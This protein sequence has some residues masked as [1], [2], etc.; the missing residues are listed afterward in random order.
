MITFILIALAAMTNA[1]MDTIAFHF[2]RS[3]FKHSTW[4]W[5]VDKYRM[6]VGGY[7]VNAWHLAKSLM[8]ML[9]V[10]GAML[11]EPIVNPYS[12]FFIYGIVWNVFFNIMF[13]KIL[14]ETK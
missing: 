14:I 4:F 3:I 1:I 10:V 11:Y 8:I 6:K 9:M 13:N 5:T 2:S 12:D 7:P